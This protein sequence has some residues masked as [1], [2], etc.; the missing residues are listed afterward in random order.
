[1][2]GLATN[3][4]IRK[5]DGICEQI[6]YADN[7]AAIGTVAQLH[8]CW[9]KLAEVGQAF[10]YFP[11]PVKTWLVTKQDHF[12]LAT[13]TFRRLGVNVTPEGRPYLSAAIGTREYIEKYV[14]SKV[15][16]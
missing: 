13:D 8:A 7:S 6:W 11:N 14:S 1:M 9:T 2:Y 10:G 5:L 16:I 15:S 4:I 3:P 12:N